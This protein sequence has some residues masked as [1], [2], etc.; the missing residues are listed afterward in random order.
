MMN[1]TMSVDCRTAKQ[2]RANV[3]SLNRGCL[4]IAPRPISW[5]TSRR[6]K[7]VDLQSST[8]TLVLFVGDSMPYLRELVDPA[9]LAC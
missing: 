5:K 2:D 1:A 9:R 8:A 4:H 3:T 7:G 6:L